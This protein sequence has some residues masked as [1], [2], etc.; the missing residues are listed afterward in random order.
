MGVWGLGFRGSM[1]YSVLWPMKDLYHQPY[2]YEWP[3]LFMLP[4]K[5]PFVPAGP[6]THTNGFRV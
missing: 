2:Y 4:D 1:V 5:A 6:H 3:R